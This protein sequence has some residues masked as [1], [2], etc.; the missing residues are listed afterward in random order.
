MIADLILFLGGACLMFLLIPLY[1]YAWIFWK[2]RWRQYR[3]AK[4]QDRLYQR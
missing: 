4:R 3:E 1:E 2:W